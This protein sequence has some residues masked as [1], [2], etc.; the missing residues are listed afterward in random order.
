M[1]TV[2]REARKIPVQCN[3]GHTTLESQEQIH[4]VE[5]K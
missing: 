2:L 1:S 3:K 5:I 4:D